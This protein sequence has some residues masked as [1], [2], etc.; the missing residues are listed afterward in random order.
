MRVGGRGVFCH[1]VSVSRQE[2]RSVT[3]QFVRGR[4][5]GYP[6]AYVHAVP[7]YVCVD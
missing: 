2:A 7:M 4:V 3:P 5:H 1:G 6:T